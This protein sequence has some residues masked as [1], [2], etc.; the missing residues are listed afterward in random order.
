M[1]QAGL[2]P[3]PTANAPPPKAPS[4]VDGIVSNNTINP[5]PNPAYRGILDTH[6]PR[7]RGGLSNPNLQAHAWWQTP[8]GM[9]LGSYNSP[10]FST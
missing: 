4:Y 1:N 5:N 2:Q 9:N 7:N 8:A 10:P 3:L 6:D